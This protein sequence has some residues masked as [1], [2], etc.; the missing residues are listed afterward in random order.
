MQSKRKLDEDC[1]LNDRFIVRKI[2]SIQAHETTHAY[3]HVLHNIWNIV[4]TYYAKWCVEVALVVIQIEKP[5]TK[6]DS[7]PT[8]KHVYVLRSPTD[9]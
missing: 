1:F 6:P 8:L 2:T 7:S 3:S 9:I 4:Q 5:H